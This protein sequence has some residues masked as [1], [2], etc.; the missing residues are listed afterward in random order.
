VRLNIDIVFPDATC[1]MT[2]VLLVWPEVETETCCKTRASDATNEV[3]KLQVIS[4][5][6]R[7]GSCMRSKTCL[8]T[9]IRFSYSEYVQL[10]PL[11]SKEKNHSRTHEKEPKRARWKRPLLCRKAR[12]SL[13]PTCV[14]SLAKRF[15]KGTEKFRKR[16]VQGGSR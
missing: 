3:E 4:G 6:I 16:Q 10:D 1:L 11:F 2:G 13:L 8:D 9:L 15:A 5:Q 12:V 7:T 14:N